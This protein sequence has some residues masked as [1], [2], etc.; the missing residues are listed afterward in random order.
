MPRRSP[1]NLT[2]ALIDESASHTIDLLRVSASQRNDVLELLDQLERN[3][4]A[5]IENY[6]GKSQ[7][8]AGRL[9][10]LLREARAIIKEAYD[11]ILLGHVDD[12]HNVAAASAGNV[13]AAVNTQIGVKLLTGKIAAKEVESIANSFVLGRPASEWWAKQAAS[14]VDRFT[15][16]MRL[17]MLQGESVPELARRL[18]GTKASGFTDG[19]MQATRNQA[20]TLVRTAAIDTGNTARLAT[21]VANR[22]L[23]TGVQWVSTLDQ[24]TTP[25]CIAL[26]GLTWSLP[27]SNDP[28]DYGGYKPIDHDKAFPGPTAHWSCRSTQVSILMPF[29]DLLS[30]DA[31]KIPAASRDK[32]DGK[33]G[34]RLGYRDWLNSQSEEK[35]NEILG[36]SKAGLWRAV[37]LDL[38]DLTNQSNRPLT[39][40]TLAAK[41]E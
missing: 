2:D 36:V 10:S 12:L 37:K 35:Q 20:E 16:E 30:G 14:L 34:E 15:V 11:S 33:T 27:N 21:F 1:L 6:A 13:L 19:I 39:A 23:I 38:T 29:D 22:D 32:M 41:Y 18:R 26:D 5:E 4:I 17:G 3:L 9:A 31:K 25:I 7:L 24:R 28:E 40:A 8:T